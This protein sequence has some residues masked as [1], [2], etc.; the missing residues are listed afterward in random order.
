MHR[1]TRRTAVIAAAVLLILGTAV[2]ASAAGTFPTFG[3]HKVRSGLPAGIGHFK[4]TSSDVRA[5]KPIPARFW[6]CGDTSISPQ[7][8]WRGAPAATKSFAVTVFD[9]DAPTGSGF[10]HWTAWDIPATTRSLPTGAALPAP[11]VN[12]VNDAGVNGYTG[13]CPPQG[14]ITHHYV[15][16][17]VALD[18]PTIEL[19]PDTRGPVA[20]YVVGQH[21]IAAGTFTATAR[22]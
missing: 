9:V 3:Y 6:G 20:G 21:A 1:I 7:L 15:F 4:L 17:V 8:S 18:V 10:W 13:P 19:T 16:T 22:Q 5:G 2:G 14:D 12:G 11:S